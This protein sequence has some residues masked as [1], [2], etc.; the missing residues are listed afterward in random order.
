MR[1]RTVPS[2]RSDDRI[3]PTSSGLRAGALLPFCQKPHISWS[4]LTL[5]R[6]RYSSS[7]SSSRR[8]RGALF[9]FA[10]TRTGP[11]SS[12]NLVRVHDP[13]AVTLLGEEEL[14]VAGELLVARVL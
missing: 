1:E 11:P 4:S 13:V 2:S 12:A 6:S 9:G 7:V 14:P 3:G 5:R 8:S 10:C